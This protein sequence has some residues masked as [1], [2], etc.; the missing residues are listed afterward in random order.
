MGTQPSKIALL[1]SSL[2]SLS[3]FSVSAEEVASHLAN[4]DETITVT[5]SRFDR[6]AD[7]QLTVINTIEREEI[8][9]L[10]P[11]SV[12]DV[13][14]TLPGVSVSRNGGAGQA[15]SVSIRGSNSNHVLVLID[16]VKVGSATL[17]TVSFNS[18]SPENIERIEV[19]KG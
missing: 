1:V 2:V 8:A 14:E 6:S 5:G 10:N 12:A 17:G 16:G 18:L 15:T 9:R 7:Q 13:L 4:V 11:K 19:L 3:A